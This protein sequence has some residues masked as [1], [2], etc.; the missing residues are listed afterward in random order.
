MLDLIL[1]FLPGRLHAALRRLRGQQI[2]RSARLGFGVYLRVDHLE[3]GEGARLGP[4]TRVRARTAVIGPR[5]VI[6]PM[7]TV[8]ATTLRMGSDSEISSL[9]II[10]GAI[11][12]ERSVLEM[13]SH[14]RI[15]PMCYLDPGHGIHL[16]DRVGVGGRSLI[17]THGSWANYFRGAP[18]AFG[19]VRIE[20]R[21][22]LPWRVFVL[23]GVVIGA[24]AIVGAGSVVT[25]S[26]PARALAGGVPA[27][28]RREVAYEEADG[29]LAQT[30]ILEAVARF[31]AETGTERSSIAVWG[32]DDIDPARTRVVLGAGIGEAEVSRT[33]EKGVGVLDVT[34]ERIWAGAQ[35]D[36]TTRLG[37]WLSIYGVRVDEAP[38]PAQ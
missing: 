10:S 14:S 1:M 38:S 26:I 37:S 18:V 27:S 35:H 29:A 5:S 9:N 22:W 7:T 15:F 8:L 2:A 19:P 23:P 20:D 28:V 11:D 33:L 16:G 17:F 34:T 31:V 21:V 32:V 25:K 36:A 12:Q 24:D 13:G 6:A 4:F 30:R 3:V